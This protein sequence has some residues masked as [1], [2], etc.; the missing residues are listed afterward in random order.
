M[1]RLHLP[2]GITHGLDFP[3][4]ENWSPAQALAVVELIDYTDFAMGLARALGFDLCPRLAHLR[5]RRLHVPV[6][7]LVPADLTTI[8]DCDVRLDA[9]EAIWDD[10]VRVAASVQSGHCTAVQALAR[11]GSAARGQPL[12]DGGVHLG[13]LFRTIFLIDYFTVPAFRGELQHALNRGEAVHNVQRAIHPGKIPVELTRHRH[14]MMAV[15]SALTLLT[16]AVMAWNTQ[17]MQ[18]ALDTIERSSATSLCYPNTCAALRRR[19]W[20]ESICAEPLI[21]RSPTMC[22]G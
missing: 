18:R 7:F 22:I 10:F 12:Y 11:F 17:H 6:D 16:N 9:I 5:D 19:H 3:I 21:F 4:P 1:K 20:K 14:S 2:S 8:T 13:R 15:S